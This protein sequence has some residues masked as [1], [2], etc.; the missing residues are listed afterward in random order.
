M[1]LDHTDTKKMAA[2]AMTCRLSNGGQRCN[3]SKRF[4]ILE[5]HYDEFVKYL[6]EHMETQI[7]GDPL[8]IST[9]LPPMSSGG[10]IDEVHAQVH[11]TVTE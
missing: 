3:A 8:D 7:L 2:I 6:T 1:L 4:I 10:L 9:T 11:K 5:Q